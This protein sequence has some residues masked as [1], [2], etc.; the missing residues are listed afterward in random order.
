[1]QHLSQ[2]TPKIQQWNV[3]KHR[4]NWLYQQIMTRESGTPQPP[5]SEGPFSTH[6]SAARGTEGQLQIVGR[7]RP[8]AQRWPRRPSSSAKQ[9]PCVVSL[10]SETTSSYLDSASV[11]PRELRRKAGV[12]Q[13]L[14]AKA[15]TSLLQ[16]RGG[17]IKLLKCTDA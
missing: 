9:H 11:R 4:K 8:G 12:L 17:G 14:E 2:T 1:M 15:H 10:S 5:S 13:N 3:R 7:R 6:A 16:G